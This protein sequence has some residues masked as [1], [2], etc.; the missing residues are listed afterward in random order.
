MT[1]EEPRVADAGRYSPTEASRLLNI[2][3]STLDRH[4]KEGYIKC[5]YRRIKEKKFY[6]GIEIKRYWKAQL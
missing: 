5:G 4:T 2:H 3:R 1:F 6:M